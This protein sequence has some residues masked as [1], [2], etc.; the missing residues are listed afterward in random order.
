MQIST[1]AYES[2]LAEIEDNALFIS[3]FRSF[4]SKH[5]TE[6]AAHFYNLGGENRGFANEFNKNL[7]H[8]TSDPASAFQGLVLQ[9][10]GVLEE[11]LGYA[12]R[13]YVEAASEHPSHWSDERKVKVER[14]FLVRAGQGLKYEPSGTWDGVDFDFQKLRENLACTL[15]A[16]K[17]SS[18]SG[19]VFVI[20]IGTCTS[21]KIEGLFKSIGFE[22][23]FSTDFGKHSAIKA[24]T[25]ETVATK[26][27]NRIKADLESLAKLRNRLAHGMGTADV[28]LNT[29]LSAT[30]L[31]RA[32]VLAVADQL[33]FD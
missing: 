32:V 15:S 10:T 9:A 28:E 18:F 29:T 3:Y 6:I 25:S 19:D 14:E 27:A 13:T 30:A 1:A 2:K 33:S 8:A 24:Y 12:I 5:R 11:F 20:R 22:G 23:L 26:S 17:P 7:T 16:E 4:L 21:D 31:V